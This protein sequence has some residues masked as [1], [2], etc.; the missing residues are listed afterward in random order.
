MSGLTRQHAPPCQPR[1]ASLCATRRGA[2]AGQQHQGAS[3]VLGVRDE[4][5]L[6]QPRGH[7]VI[8]EAR[9]KKRPGGT[10]TQAGRRQEVS[11]MYNYA[12]NLE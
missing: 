4:R 11:M 7:G 6:W 3:L 1:R 2:G 9:G 10:M 5:H 8:I 12:N